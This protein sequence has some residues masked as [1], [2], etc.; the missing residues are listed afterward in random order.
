[1]SASIC[2]AAFASAAN[3][4]EGGANVAYIPRA[5]RSLR[6]IGGGAQAGSGGNEGWEYYGDL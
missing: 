5:V 2:I 1:V 3:R 6:S 4:C